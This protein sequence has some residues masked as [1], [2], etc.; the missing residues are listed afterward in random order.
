VGGDELSDLLR[1]AVAN[2]E[3][4]DLGR[5]T[6][7]QTALLEVGILGDDGEAVGTRIIP[8]L[9]VGKPQRTTFADVRAAGEKRREQ[10]GQ[11]RREVLVKQQLYAGR[12]SGDGRGRR[13]RR[14]RLGCRQR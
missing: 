8:N 10:A 3:P 12:R 14:S 13:R 2:A 9:L 4:D 6:V 1:G 5:L 11:L 7:E